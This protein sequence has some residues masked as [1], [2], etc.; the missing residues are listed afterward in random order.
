M[1]GFSQ[2]NNL[3]S[4]GSAII[5]LGSPTDIC[6]Q[7]ERNFLLRSADVRGEGTQDTRLRMSAGEA[8]AWQKPITTLK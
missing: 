8:K 3:A 7:W 5:C 1:I 2:N 4:I 6:E